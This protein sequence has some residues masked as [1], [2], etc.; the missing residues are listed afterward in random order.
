[1]G[2]W[3]VTRSEQGPYRGQGWPCHGVTPQ[4]RGLGLVFLPWCFDGDQV[5]WGPAYPT[6]SEALTHARCL[7]GN[8]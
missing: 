5:T 2:G 4:D 6:H 7:A 8:A 3:A 1:V